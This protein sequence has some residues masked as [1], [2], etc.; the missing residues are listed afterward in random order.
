[1][2]IVNMKG[3]QWQEEA[4]EEDLNER[5]IIGKKGMAEQSFFY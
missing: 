5:N 2:P 4:N 1:M 3:K